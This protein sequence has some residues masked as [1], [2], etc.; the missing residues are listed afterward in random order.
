[1]GMNATGMRDRACAHEFCV[2]YKVQSCPLKR[3]CHLRPIHQ[4]VAMQDADD[5]VLDALNTSPPQWQTLDD[6]KVIPECEGDLHDVIDNPY[7]RRTTSINVA[8]LMDIA[9]M[10]KAE[11]V[12]AETC[13]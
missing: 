2:N 12:P 4:D 5:L 11:S 10:G 1:M 9:K 6:I 7:A 3:A 13:S 8:A